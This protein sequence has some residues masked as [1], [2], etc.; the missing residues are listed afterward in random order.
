MM[1]SIVAG[2][3]ARVQRGEDQ[4]AR[5]G[6]G[7]RG[8]DRLEVA[9]LAE[10][11]HVGVLAEGGAERLGEAAR[12]GADLALVDEAAAVA[13]EELDRVLDREDVARAVAV[14]LVDHRGERRRLPRAG[15]AGDEHEAARPLG[16]LVQDRPGGRAPRACR[17]LYGIRRNAAPT[18]PRWKKTLTR[19]RATPE[20]A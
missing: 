18:A 13:V 3:A 2:R 8:R 20:I 9:H 19:K 11:D 5:L 17:I 7:Q 10:E 14:D 12:V 16:Q 15:R 4:V 1:R 6:G